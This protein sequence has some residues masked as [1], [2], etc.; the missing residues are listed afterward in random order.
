MQRQRA[1][2]GSLLQTI[3][4]SDSAPAK[5]FRPIFVL[6]L[7][8]EISRPR[9]HLYCQEFVSLQCFRG[10][11]LRKFARSVAS[12][13]PNNTAKMTLRDHFHEGRN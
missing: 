3:Y 5:D 6:T 11:I 1:R 10:A 7:T 4:I 9:E 12:G 8:S 2:R 13:H